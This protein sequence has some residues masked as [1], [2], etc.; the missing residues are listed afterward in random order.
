[1]PNRPVMEVV[2]NGI[3]ACDDLPKF[4]PYY[5]YVVLLRNTY[6]TIFTHPGNTNAVNT[7]SEALVQLDP[8]DISL[9]SVDASDLSLYEHDAHWPYFERLWKEAPVHY[10]KDNA[11][12][13]CWSVTKHGDIMPV[14]VYAR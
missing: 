14:R 4:E 5:E 10:C 1:M 8:N 3:L 12:G 6:S 2:R 9:I 7:L 13:P 11:L